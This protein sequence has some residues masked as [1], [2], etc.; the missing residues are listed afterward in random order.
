[1]SLVL[2]SKRVIAG[3]ASIVSPFWS[4][5]GNSLVLNNILC[6]GIASIV[7][8][9]WRTLGKWLRESIGQRLSLGNTRP[10]GILMTHLVGQ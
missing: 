3:I 5:L 9:L 7:S 4:A 1:M 8:C 10:N 2:K 6:L